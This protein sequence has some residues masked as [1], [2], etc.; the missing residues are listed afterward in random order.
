MAANYGYT[1]PGV[2]ISEITSPAV[3]PIFER[4]TN[5][6][7]VGEALGYQSVSN[8]VVYLEDN[9]PT[10]LKVSGVITSSIVIKDA[11]NT[12][13]TYVSGTDYTIGT[14]GDFTTISRKL[15]TSIVSGAGLAVIFWTTGDNTKTRVVGDVNAGIVYLNGTSATIVAAPDATA[16]D[17]VVVQTRGLYNTTTD[18]QVSVTGTTIAKVQRKTGSPRI[19]DGQ[20]VYVSYTTASGANTYVDEAFTLIGTTLSSNFAHVTESVDSAS[21]KVRNAAN[22]GYSDTSAVTQYVEGATSDYTKA[23]DNGATPF[24]T[25]TITRTAAAPTTIGVADNRRTVRVSYNSVSS[26]YYM[27]LR[28][29]NYQDVEN[30]FG[31]AFDSTTGTIVSPLSFGAYLAFANGASDIVAQAV[32]TT[33]NIEDS[34]ATRSAPRNKVTDISGYVA[35]WGY[36]FKSLRSFSDVN[37]IV[38]LIGQDAYVTDNSVLSVLQALQDHVSYMADNDE[39]IFILTGED[40]GTNG[41]ASLST[42]QNHARALGAHTYAERTALVSPASFAF[43]TQASSKGYI[44]IGGQYV[45]AAL[46]GQLAKRP[47]QDA[48]TRKSIVGVI[49]VLDYR[50]KLDKDNDAQSGLLVVERRNGLVAVRHAT[51]TAVSSVNS[52]EIS[53]VRAKLYMVESIRRTVDNQIIGQIIADENAPTIVG[54]TIQGVLQNLVQSGAIVS[55]SGLQARPLPGLPTQ[56]E[57]R[58]SYKPSYPLNYVSIVFSIDVSTGATTTFGA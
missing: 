6:A 14:S 42:L 2:S 21:I 19:S 13:T 37:V 45:A 27:P 38:P 17:N 33:S 22:M 35:D 44:S 43:P 32:F 58:F 34:Q 18:Y 51:T 50:T 29:F 36:S 28:F 46:S 9:L 40:S 52:Q 31:A 11:Y 47:I 20:I 54:V 7:I 24:P 55:F 25:A 41:R 56:I 30:K 3:A 39:H 53:V 1:P 10:T 49:D 16:I 23:V 48:L 57:V 8:E 4:P 15:Y 5:I 26:D 12:S